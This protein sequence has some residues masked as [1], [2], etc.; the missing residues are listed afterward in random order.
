[1]TAGRVPQ[2]AAE[3]SPAQGRSEHES[4]RI[5]MRERTRTGSNAALGRFGERDVVRGPAGKV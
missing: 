1:L 2:I 3:A 4:E 5:A